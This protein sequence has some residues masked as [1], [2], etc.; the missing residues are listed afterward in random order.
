MALPK[1]MLT[2]LSLDLMSG[3]L[4]K[5]QPS[6]LPPRLSDPL[7]LRRREQLAQGFPVHH[8]GKRLLCLSDR[9]PAISRLRGQGDSYLTMDGR[10]QGRVMVRDWPAQGPSDKLSVLTSGLALMT[11]PGCPGS[12]IHER[13]P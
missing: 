11:Q 10:T 3:Q 8:L 7:R 6:S 12:G 4:G 2:V 9:L 13:I 5:G 1:L